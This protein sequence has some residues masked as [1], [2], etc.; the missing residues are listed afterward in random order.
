M[1]STV[2]TKKEC[3]YVIECHFCH[4]QEE[5]SDANPMMKCVRGKRSAL[6]NRECQLSGWKAH[7][8]RMRMMLRHSGDYPGP[9]A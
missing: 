6:C 5:V 3:N 8:K 7:K 1:T 9:G 2:S 4:R